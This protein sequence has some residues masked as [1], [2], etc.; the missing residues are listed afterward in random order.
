MLS[1]SHNHARTFTDRT[2]SLLVK[3]AHDTK[4]LQAC[5]VSARETQA[6]RASIPTPSLP[7][8]MNLT[9]PLCT[10]P[11][12]GKTERGRELYVCERETDR[13]GEPPLLRD[14]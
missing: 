5:P 13:E 8:R 6:F 2:D 4:E 1:H 9:R 14:E 7:S 3:G 10:A 11:R 12:L